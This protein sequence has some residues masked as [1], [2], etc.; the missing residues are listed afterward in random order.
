MY[1]FKFSS[2]CTEKKK[3]KKNTGKTN[4]IILFTSSSKHQHVINTKTINEIFY[5]LVPSFQIWNVYLT[6]EGHINSY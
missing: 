1:N 6:F 3:K 5:F 4:F 2:N